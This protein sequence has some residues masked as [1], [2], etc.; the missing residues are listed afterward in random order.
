MK[1]VD[2]SVSALSVHTSVLHE[3]W[4]DIADVKVAAENA[5]ATEDEAQKDILSSQWTLWKT[6]FDAPGADVMVPTAMRRFGVHDDAET[7][8]VRHASGCSSP[9]QILVLMLRCRIIEEIRD[10]QI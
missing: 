1:S 7:A 6:I 9:K 5:M 4:N 10:R 2:V 3:L 8:W